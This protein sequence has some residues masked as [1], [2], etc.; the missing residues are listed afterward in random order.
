[1][2]PPHTDKENELS[3]S[4]LDTPAIERLRADLA[5]IEEK[6]LLNYTLADAIREGCSVTDKYEGGWIQGGQACA[7][8]AAWI[9]GQA[10]GLLKQ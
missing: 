10:R 5:E 3:T 4:I 8:G 1:V 9:A 7:L 6:V 2:T